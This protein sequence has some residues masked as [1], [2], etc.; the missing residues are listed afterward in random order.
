MKLVHMTFRFE[1]TDRI[2]K[3]LDSQ[4]ISD[5]VQY[6]M[7]QGKGIDGKHMGTKIFPGNFSVIQAVVPDDRV[8]AL[9]AEFDEFRKRKEAHYHIRAIV[10]P[11]ESVTG[12]SY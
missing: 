12:G 8:A 6:P 5:Y 10:M 9:L 3:L 2:N 7:V 11:I 1:Y 4:E